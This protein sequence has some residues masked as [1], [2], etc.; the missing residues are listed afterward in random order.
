MAKSF[1]KIEQLMETNPLES[2]D[3]MDNQHRL[4]KGYRELNQEEI[5][6]MNL[7]KNLEQEVLLTLNNIVR[8]QRVEGR[9]MSIARTHIEQGFMAAG[10]AVARP[11]GYPEKDPKRTDGGSLGMPEKTEPDRV[12]EAQTKGPTG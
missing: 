4:I 5:N 7:L 8:S 1:A 10:R 6:N 11:D 9:W 3:T 2:G 12:R